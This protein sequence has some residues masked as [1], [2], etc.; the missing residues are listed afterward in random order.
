[1]GPSFR[2]FFKTDYSGIALFPQ[3][4]RTYT[5]LLLDQLDVFFGYQ[6]VLG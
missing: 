2:T 1:M 5:G 4:R 3:S 6:S